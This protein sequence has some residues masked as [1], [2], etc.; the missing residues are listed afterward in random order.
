MFF[1][2]FLGINFI[3]LNKKIRINNETWRINTKSLVFMLEIFKFIQKYMLQKGYKTYDRMNL[4]RK[5]MYKKINIWRAWK[6]YVMCL[7][8]TRTKN[9][10]N[11]HFIY[12]TFKIYKTHIKAADLWNEGKGR[13]VVVSL[14]FST[15]IKITYSIW[16]QK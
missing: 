4:H 10:L 3:I 13:F 11:I 12:I 5:I 15:H 14:H 9:R 8:H 2:S 6:Y 7:I 16:I 1:V